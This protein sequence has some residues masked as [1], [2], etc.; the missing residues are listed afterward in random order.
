MNYKKKPI[1]NC[2]FWNVHPEAFEVGSHKKQKLAKKILSNIYKSIM[3]ND[4]KD[5][6]NKDVNKKQS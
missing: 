5:L 3:A 2:V 4:R 1:N 6:D